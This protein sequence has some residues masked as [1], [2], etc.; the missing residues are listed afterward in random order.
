MQ[1]IRPDDKKRENNG[2]LVFT[3][4]ILENALTDTYT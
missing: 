3:A 2:G 4:M 1:F